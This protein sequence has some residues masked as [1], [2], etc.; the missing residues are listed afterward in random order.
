MIQ[1]GE[2]QG[3]VGDGSR[4][5]VGGRQYCGLWSLT[6]KHR[7]FNAFG[8]SYAG[9][10]PGE[11]R[12]KPHALRVVDERTVEL[13]RAA[14]QTYPS[15]C[16]A[17]YQVNEPHYIDHSLTIVDRSDMLAWASLAAERELGLRPGTLAVNGASNGA[18]PPRA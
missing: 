12:G 11:L 9:L 8:N 13:S 4:D 6:S 15:D 14:D 17:A 2:I 1:A 3:I 7:Q 18:T 10:L 5:G 16:V